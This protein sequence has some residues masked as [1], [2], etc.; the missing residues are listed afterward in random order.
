MVSFDDFSVTL[1]DYTPGLSDFRTSIDG[2]STDFYGTVARHLMKKKKKFLSY[3][4]LSHLIVTLKVFITRRPRAPLLCLYFL[5][6]QRN[7]N[8]GWQCIIGLIRK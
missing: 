1:A 4:V 7:I 6:L 5:R 2:H 8:N 3:P